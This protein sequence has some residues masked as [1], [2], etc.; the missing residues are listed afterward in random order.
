MSE[1]GNKHTILWFIIV[2]LILTLAGLGGYIYWDKTKQLNKNGAENTAWMRIQKFEG[3]LQLDSLEAA[4][5]YYQWNFVHGE[6]ADQVRILK[7]QIEIEKKDWA[8]AR[9]SDSVEE[10]ED[11][12]RRH[13]NSFFRNE[14]NNKLDS[15]S[16]VDAED[17]DT[18]SSYQNYLDSFN[19]G[20]YAKKAREKMK[21]LDKGMVTESETEVTGE[22]INKHFVA[23]ATN[24]S[25]MLKSTVAD[26]V[27]S[28]IG[29][30]NLSPEDVD[31]YMQNIHAI[32][33]RKISFSIQNLIVNKDVNEHIP[34]YIAHFF[35]QEFIKYGGKTDRMNFVGMAK[36]NNNNRITSLIL[37]EQ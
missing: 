12:I 5:S 34:T 37:S 6:H 27:T 20:I 22:V 1:S 15:L 24:N 10:I 9:Y 16:Y 18:Y 17:V 11:F 3:E 4:I 26:V 23:L 33:G 31:K 35:M 28:Y 25:K 19:D 32:E 13:S 21:K 7:D 36:I 2:V 30:C 14:A 29:K 8:S